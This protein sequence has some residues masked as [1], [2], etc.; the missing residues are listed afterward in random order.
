M[1]WVNISNFL[2]RFKE[3]KPSKVLIKE[4]IIE[5]VFEKT[6][7]ELS[8]GEVDYN[9]GVIYIKTKNSGIKNQIFINKEKIIKSLSEK[10][11]SA[12]LKEIRF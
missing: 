5:V 4:K 8:S 10:I 9:S 11:G 1:S 6:Q 12:F 7:I 2:S 3:F